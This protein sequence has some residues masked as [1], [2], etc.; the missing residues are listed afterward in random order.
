MPVQG[1]NRHILRIYQFLRMAAKNYSQPLKQLQRNICLEKQF[2]FFLF[3]LFRLLFLFENQKRR[4]D[5]AKQCYGVR[6]QGSV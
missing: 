1:M 4:L 2:F 5:E 3:F 6:L